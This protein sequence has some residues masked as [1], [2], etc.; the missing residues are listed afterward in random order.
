VASL[1]GADQQQQK[2]QLDL[3]K[4]KVGGGNGEGNG[5]KESHPKVRGTLHFLDVQV[6]KEFTFL[7]YITAGSVASNILNII[8]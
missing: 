3:I 6:R 8:K 4:P 1:A 2:R 7:D 5:K